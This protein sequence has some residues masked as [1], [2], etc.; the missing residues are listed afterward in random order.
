M[1]V[2]TKI[3]VADPKQNVSIFANVSVADMQVRRMDKKNRHG[4]N[5]TFHNNKGYIVVGRSPYNGQFVSM[6]ETD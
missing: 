3:L 2:E 4:K 6:K 1:Q 5:G